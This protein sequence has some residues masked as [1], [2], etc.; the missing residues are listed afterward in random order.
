MVT[1]ALG[2]AEKVSIKKEQAE[3]LSQTLG[4]AGWFALA[5]VRQTSHILGN[6]NRADFGFRTL[7]YFYKLLV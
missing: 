4:S 1:K 2:L 6:Y 7:L 3:Q 5:G